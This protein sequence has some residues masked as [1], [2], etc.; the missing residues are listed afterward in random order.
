MARIPRSRHSIDDLG[1]IRAGID[2]HGYVLEKKLGSGGFA[3]VWRARAQ[4]GVNIAVK[5]LHPR[6][7]RRDPRKKGPSIAQRFLDE[8]RV[9][10]KA[11][12]PGVVRVLEVLEDEE[13]DII[14]YTME[15]L[16]GRDLSHLFG[17]MEGI[18]ILKAFISVCQTL[19]GIHLM[20]ILHRDIKS[21]NIF[22]CDD[23]SKG[24]YGVKLIDFGVA[25]NLVTQN[26]SESTATGVMIGTIQTLAPESI[27]RLS[28]EE[29]ELTWSV[30]QWGTG[31]ALYHCL[32]SRLPFNSA[33]TIELINEIKH[34]AMPK[35]RV[36]ESTGLQNVE[37]DLNNVLARCLEK[38]PENRFSS[39]LEVADSLAKIVN[40]MREGE[41]DQTLE[42]LSTSQ[43]QAHNGEGSDVAA[44][45][46]APTTYN[47]ERSR[48]KLKTL[49]TEQYIDSVADSEVTLLADE[50]MQPSS[51]NQDDNNEKSEEPI[52]FTSESEAMLS[53]TYIPLVKRPH[54]MHE[55]P[56]IEVPAHTEPKFSLTTILIIVAVS[57]GLSFCL[58][59]FL[60]G[61]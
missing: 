60:R 37:G 46:E 5:I 16:E 25:K 11:T 52:G 15:L 54:Q 29:T 7:R 36:R 59:W 12:L 21:A 18:E 3:S 27:R 2:L 10:S 45:D 14:A 30:D 17:K 42:N 61:L 34:K 47:I 19:H 43:I 1:E 51:A 57:V 35:L 55:E 4:N 23:P 22:I 38:L 44:T 31:V 13:R 58:G 28:G 56:K 6:H 8:A 41:A 26:L 24:Q 32:S 53:D 33:N 39:M 48:K 49:P 50:L 20:G 9:L 40:K